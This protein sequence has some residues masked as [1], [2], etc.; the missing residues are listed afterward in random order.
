MLSSV[1]SEGLY[2]ANEA[3]RRDFES[4][5]AQKR[6]AAVAAARG[7]GVPALRQR[8]SGPPDAEKRFVA[9]PSWV[10]A[11]ETRRQDLLAEADNYR[12]AM[13]LPRAARGPALLARMRQALGA[14]LQR[15]GQRLRGTP[16]IP[17]PT[18]AA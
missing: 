17:A 14:G 5:A 16:K 2:Q 7:G 12:L 18:G 6:R 13:Q 11:A 3:R 15:A 10:A 9:M 1:P 4:R 8:V